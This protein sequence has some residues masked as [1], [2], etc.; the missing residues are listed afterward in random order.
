[1]QPSTPTRTPKLPRQIVKKD[2]SLAPQHEVFRHAKA[3][4]KKKKQREK[5]K[6][7]KRKR[8]KRKKE[9]ER[10]KNINLFSSSSSY[11]VS[12]FPS[13]LFLHT[14]PNTRIG[15]MVQVKYWVENM[16]FPLDQD[17]Y[18]CT[19]L[20]YS[21]LCRHANLVSYL[22]KWYDCILI[23]FYCIFFFFFHFFFSFFLFSFFFLFIFFM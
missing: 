13:Y 15:N 16:K 11:S 3:G 19:L 9:K 4:T 21:A 2:A 8:K 22:L 7:K 23:V 10:R 18:G 20:Y 5:E 6:K 14:Q 17:F 1:M 12:I